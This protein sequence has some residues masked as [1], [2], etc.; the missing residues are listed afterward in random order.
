MLWQLLLHRFSERL[1][2]STDLSFD[3]SITAQPPSI[4]TLAALRRH[5]GT[6]AKKILLSIGGR[7]F[8]VSS[9]QLYR[10]GGRYVVFAGRACTRA[11]VL[12]SLEESDIN[13]RL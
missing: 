7:V 12:P 11:V 13:E 8:D 5:N 4:F 2:L 6:D 10:T 1:Q 3:E 9:S